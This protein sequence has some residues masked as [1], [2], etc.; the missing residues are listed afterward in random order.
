MI[1]EPAALASPLVLF[2]T[3]RIIAEPAIFYKETGGPCH[4]VR[5]PEENSYRTGRSSIQQDNAV[6]PIQSEGCVLH[7]PLG[8]FHAVLEKLL[9]EQQDQRLPWAFPHRA[10]PL[11]PLKLVKAGDESSL[12]AGSKLGAT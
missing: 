3:R 2:R 6:I 7:R 9:W 12:M 5:P 11:L 10:L 1:W 4:V 8:P